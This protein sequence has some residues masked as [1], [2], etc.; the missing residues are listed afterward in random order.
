[1]AL[2]RWTIIH[3][4]WRRALASSASANGRTGLAENLGSGGKQKGRTLGTSINETVCDMYGGRCGGLEAKLQVS[5]LT[6]GKLVQKLNPSRRGRRSHQRGCALPPGRK[7]RPRR[8]LGLGRLKL[9]ASLRRKHSSRSL[10]NKPAR[11]VWR[12]LLVQGSSRP[13]RTASFSVR[14]CFQSIGSVRVPDRTRGYAV[15]EARAFIGS[16]RQVCGG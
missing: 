9:A 12:S 13:L 15:A 4:G 10:R 6:S 16:R 5:S 1:M 7:R 3:R 11:S 14:D 2:D 8:E